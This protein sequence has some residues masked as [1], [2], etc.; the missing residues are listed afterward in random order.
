MKTKLKI[1]NIEL[2]NNVF[3]A[4]MAGYTDAGFRALAKRYGAGLT[5]TEMVSAKALSMNSKKTEELLFSTSEE[6]PIAVQ[7]FGHEEEAFKLAIESGKLDKFDIIDINMGCPAP[8][9]VGNR[10]GSFL[11]TEIDHA[12]RIIETCV[13][14][15]TKP[16]SV[17]FRS[18]F[19]ENNIVAVEFAKMCETAGAAFITV[20]PRTKTQGYSGTA[21]WNIIKEVTKAVKIPVIASGDIKSTED[22]DYLIKECGAAGVMIGRASLGRPE[23]FEEIIFRKKTI[24]SLKD[25]LNQIREHIEILSRFFN[26]KFVYLNMKKHI[27]CYLR[28]FEGVTILREKIC[29][30]SSLKEMLEL[31]ENYAIKQE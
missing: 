20:H 13:Q 27:L 23:I 16:V 22:V 14:A 5:F 31:I 2:K 1:K 19:D 9:I 29:L 12:R 10:E 17:K 8:K 4:P 28:D 24:L 18:G 11:M 21:D 25:K 6:T 30:C 3:L 26:E 7:L 15:T